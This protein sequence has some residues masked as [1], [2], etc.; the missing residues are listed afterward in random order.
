MEELIARTEAINHIKHFGKKDP[1]LVI[2]NS[3]RDAG[4][5]EKADR[6]LKYREEWED[7]RKNQTTP[8][9]PL[10]VTL[11]LSDTCNLACAHCYRQYNPDK[12]DHRHLAFEVIRGIVDQCS[13]LN[14][15]SIGVGTESESL[16][17]DRIGDVIQYVGDKQ[18]TDFWLFTNGILL[19]DEIVQTILSN[20][21]T[22]LTVSIDAITEPTYRK[23][24]GYG[25]YKLMSNV[26][27][28]LDQR[29]KSGRRVPVLRIS[30]VNYNLNESER[31]DFVKFWR[32]IADEIDVQ[33]LI[34]VKNV[35]ILKYA[36]IEDAKCLYPDNMLYINW[37]GDY[38]PCCSEFCKHLTIGNVREMTMIEAWNSEYMQGLRQEFKKLKPVNR[39]CLNCLQSLRSREQYDPVKLESPEG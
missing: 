21:V 10:F 15:P 23:T 19:D 34:D 14:V 20:N 11:G 1:N 37:N 17:Y 22:R 9:R 39:V 31:E 12:T 36:E 27:N 38:K 29:Q 25:F 4:E 6:F 8:D 18:F 30:F 33:S 35:D 28:F 24:R 7:V 13:D 5:L 3:Y 2:Y 32:E 16:L 26:F